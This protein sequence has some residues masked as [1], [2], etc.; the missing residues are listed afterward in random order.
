M[1]FLI[2]K[3]DNFINKQVK[4]RSRREAAKYGIR[5]LPPEEP[6]IPKLPKPPKA[7][8]P[9]GYRPRQSGRKLF[10]GIVSEVARQI[11]PLGPY[12]SPGDIAGDIAESK[13]LAQKIIGIKK[14]NETL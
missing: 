14:K 5:G 1:N 12:R 4:F 9:G 7:A 11:S 8:L 13:R 3:I 10:D 6:K 2:K